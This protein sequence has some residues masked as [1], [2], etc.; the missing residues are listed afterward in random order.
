MPAFRTFRSRPSARIALLALAC[1]LLAACATQRGMEARFDRFDLWHEPLQFGAEPPAPEAVAARFEHDFGRYFESDA[2][3]RLDTDDLKLLFRATHMTARA[4][5]SSTLAERLARIISELQSRNALQAWQVAYWQDSLLA[6]RQ[7]DAARAVRLAHPDVAMA[8]VPEYVDRA[9]GNGPSVLSLSADA[10]MLTRADAS[11][12]ET[13]L[14]IVF[15]EGCGFSQRAL[16]AL[17]TQPELADLLR[18]RTLWMRPATGNLHPE[19]WAAW[20]RNQSLAP[21]V[22]AYAESEWP[23]IDYWGTPT[24]YVLRDGQ[25]HAKITGWPGDEQLDELTRAVRS[26]G[27]LDP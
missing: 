8:Q 17:E 23:W 10:G 21:L 12:P 19:A 4:S 15:G 6:A 5:P 27:L 2:F 7:F 9:S 16:A 26:A 14:V 3:Q 24:F 18:N 22:E 20:N 13:G 1:A 25:L 11:L